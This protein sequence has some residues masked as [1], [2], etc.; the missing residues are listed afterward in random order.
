MI[1][2]KKNKI[3]LISAAT[4]MTVAPLAVLTNT[5]NEVQAATTKAVMH[6]ALAYDKDGNSTGVKYNAYQY[7]TVESNPVKIDGSLYYK[8]SGKDQY[9][10]ATNI[11]GVTRKITHNTYIYRTSTGRTSYN[12]RWKLYK[13]ET[14]TTYGGS[15]KF[16]NGKHY[17]RIGGPNKQYI[18]SYNLGPVISVNTN[19]NTSSSSSQT[20]KSEETTVTVTDKRAALFVEVPDK[21]AVQ[22]SGKYAKQGDKFT[23]DRLEQGTRAD[24]GRDGDDDNELAIYHI[25]GTD[26]WI[27]NFNVKAAKDIPV[28]NYYHTKK[29][30]IQ[31]IKPTDIYDANGNK[32]DFKGDQVR[33]QGGRYKVNKLLYIWVPSENKAELF[34]HLVG[35]SVYSNQG[36]V[37]FADGYVKASD[38]RFDPNS[39]S[40]TPSNTAAEAEA[41]AQKK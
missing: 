20:T 1:M 3:A 16:K 33:K 13:G 6:T 40:L 9:I 7:V 27:Y 4:L 32:I 29:S 2:M 18:K 11:D 38:V 15:Y 24:T 10:K 12:N 25:K 19:N 14:I 31:F 26:Y 37:Q 5:T 28:Q 35:K 39:T 36:E 22:P 23:V 8:V 21:D 41:A 17:F 30:L 34:Y